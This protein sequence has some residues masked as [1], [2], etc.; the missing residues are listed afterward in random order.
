MGRLFVCLI[1]SLAVS[2]HLPLQRDVFSI[3][4]TGDILL[5][6][7]IRQQ[8][9]VHGVDS[10]FSRIKP[11]LEKGSYVVGNL[12]NPATTILNP[13]NKRYVFRS[14][15]GWLTNLRKAGFTHFNVANN[16]TFDQGNSGFL[17]TI[18]NLYAT[19]IMPVGVCHH[20]DSPQPVMVTAGSDTCLLF[21]S[22]LVPPELKEKLPDST[23]PCRASAEL[24]TGAIRNFRSQHP[25]YLL[26][27]LLHWGREYNENYTHEQENAAFQLIDA[28]ADAVIGHHPH[29]LEPIKMHNGKPIFYSLGNLVF[30]QQQPAAQRSMIVRIIIRNHQIKEVEIYPVELNQGIP[31]WSRRNSFI[32]KLLPPLTKIFSVIPP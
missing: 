32:L 9:R 4:F 12:E 23:G 8:I 30:D 22:N 6:R 18:S 15:P 27:T 26:F 19:A 13:Q 2:C 24:L 10:I 5:D 16:H 14:D 20:A 17:E 31:Q 11:V 29:V 7:G 1:V 25:Q 28:G 3:V 21:A